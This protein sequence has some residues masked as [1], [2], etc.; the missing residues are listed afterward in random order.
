MNDLHFVT[1]HWVSSYFRADG[2]LVNGYWRDGDGDTSVNLNMINGGGYFRTNPDGNPYNNLGAV[3]PNQH[4]VEGYFRKDGTFVERHLRTN[5][6]DNEF[7]NLNNNFG[8]VNNQNSNSESIDNI[9]VFI[10]EADSKAKYFNPQGD[11]PSCAI[12]AEESV[13]EETLNVDVNG[14]LL[15]EVATNQG[16]YNTETGIEFQNLGNLLEKFG[17]EIERGTDYRFDQLIEALNSNEKVIVGLNASEIR[18]PQYDSVGNSINQ[19]FVGHAVKVTGIGESESGDIYVIV[20]DSAFENGQA[21]AILLKDFMNAWDD[22]NNLTVITNLDGEI[23]KEEIGTFESDMYDQNMSS[24]IHNTLGND[25]FYSSSDATVGEAIDKTLGFQFGDMANAFATGGYIAILEILEGNPEKQKKVI[26]AG[27]ALGAIDGIVNVDGIGID[28]NPLLI[29]SLA[30]W[31]LMIGKD[32]KNEKV[33]KFANNFGSLMSKSFKVVGAV[34][35]T[36]LGVSTID[37]LAPTLDIVDS[38]GGVADGVLGAAGTFAD[39]VDGFASLGLGIAA[40]K[41]V[42]K[43]MDNWNNGDIEIISELKRRKALKE[44]ARELI[45]TDAPPK[46]LVGVLEEV[47]K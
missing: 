36:A 45:K 6:D 12:R 4:T 42:K 29:A 38:I 24:Y 5:P 28:I 40:S 43:G 31:V 26:K 13:I 2:T 1:P 22:T 25:T 34:G 27:L 47:R 11:E 20:S 37:F 18:T 23:I 16:W 10:G 39:I 15:D 41:V 44:L 14:S 8:A 9:N 46:M 33:G 21:N 32:C 19:E 30:T 35:Y 3:N 7:N 17:I